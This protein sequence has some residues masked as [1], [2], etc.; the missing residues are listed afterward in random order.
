MNDPG[1]LL[2]FRSVEPDTTAAYVR[3]NTTHDCF[4]SQRGYPSSKDNNK[5]NKLRLPRKNH[6]KIVV[7][8]NKHQERLNNEA[9][10]DSLEHESS[11][12]SGTFSGVNALR[13]WRKNAYLGNENRH[14]NSSINKQE[15]AT[16]NLNNDK[17]HCIAD[18]T[19][20][21]INS[22]MKQFPNILSDATR[23]EE[24]LSLKYLALNAL[25]LTAPASDVLLKNR[26][27]SWFQL[28]GHPD[29]FA[30]AGPG[31]VWKRRTGGLENTERNV[32]ESLSKDAE[33]RECIPR[34]YREVEYKGETFIELQDLLF[35]FNDP[36]VMDIKLGTRTFLESEVSKTTERPD[37]YLK[38]IAVDPNAPSSLE[39]EK[40]AVTKLR[41]MQFREQ[42]SSTC[43]HGFRIE[44]MKLPGTP[45]ITELKTVKSHDQVLR[46]M[47]LFLSDGAKTRVRLLDRLRDIRRRVESS[48]YFQTH[49][50]IGSSI[51][52]IYDEEKVGVWLIDFAKTY[53]VS[54][55]QT[56]THRAQ[57][58]EGNH[59]EGFLFG[60]DNLISI[61]EEVDNLL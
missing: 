61:I 26:L 48:K 37:L 8:R 53:K 29:G 12:S 1:F 22:T 42:Q 13:Q 21:L 45:P 41:Y 19:S 52:M 7:S 57:W 56:L 51:F 40:K 47:K 14:D 15:S 50:I 60:L 17:S 10:A 9:R 35:G 44:A 27:K 49:E 38:M 24:D 20:I 43:S 6:E 34:Y 16:S 25:E 32:Y 39:H 31:T 58:K 46:T 11:T 2:T 54:E 28:S 36:H 33:M 30:P 23:P 4:E 5:D 18:S 59:E 55:G 3:Y